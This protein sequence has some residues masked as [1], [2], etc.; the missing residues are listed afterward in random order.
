MFLL[1]ISETDITKAVLF[2]C[3]APISPPREADTGEL[4]NSQLARKANDGPF[5]IYD[6][7]VTAHFL[8]I[9]A[10]LLLLFCGF[11]EKP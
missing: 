5:F 6:C 3:H 2:C 7:S 1:D 8:H 10:F 4:G 9:C 11:R